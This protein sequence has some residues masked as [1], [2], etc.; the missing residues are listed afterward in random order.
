MR[1]MQCKNTDKHIDHG[2]IFAV[3]KSPWD[4][5]IF[6]HFV[7]IVVA[8]KEIAF[9][10]VVDEK[11]AENVC[12]MQFGAVKMSN[13]ISFLHTM[14]NNNTHIYFNCIW[15]IAFLKM[16]YE[17]FMNK[18]NWPDRNVEINQPKIWKTLTQEI[19]LKTTTETALFPRTSCLFNCGEW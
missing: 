14:L 10:N 1:F 17:F 19:W 8:N 13:S 7:R 18:P 9:I 4:C 16:F 5:M 12:E 15:Y 11:A 3:N 2:K 6:I